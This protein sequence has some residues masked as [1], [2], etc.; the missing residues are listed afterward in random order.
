MKKIILVLLV[1]IIT[2]AGCE[3]NNN[4]NSKVEELLGKYQMLDD[5]INVTSY[6]ISNSTDLDNDTE[7]E[8]RKI[9]E[10]QYKNLSYEIKDEE[11]D[12]DNATVTVEIEVINYKKVLEKYPRNDYSKEKYNDKVIKD[13][14]DIKERTV[15]TIEFSLTKDK[16][17]EWSVDPLTNDIENKL[18]GIY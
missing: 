15:Y 18:L 14:Q 10:R 7:E 4:P 2:L 3:L 12:G 16:K 13:L 11:T 9:I 17:G 8:Y 6:P 1:T 5:S